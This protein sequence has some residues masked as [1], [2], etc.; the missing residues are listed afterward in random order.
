MKSILKETCEST[1]RFADVIIRNNKLFLQG[2]WQEIWKPDATLQNRIFV[3]NKL[4]LTVQGSSSISKID[5]RKKCESM[6]QGARRRNCKCNHQT[7][8]LV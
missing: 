1:P 2:L 7:K 4:P 3:K 5:L 6:E 8:F